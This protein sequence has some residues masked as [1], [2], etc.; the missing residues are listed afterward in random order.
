MKNRRTEREAPNGARMPLLTF[1]LSSIPLFLD[2]QRLTN[3]VGIISQGLRIAPPEAPVTG[4]V[5]AHR[6]TE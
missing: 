6:H 4:F 2:S 1:F 3:F 5:L